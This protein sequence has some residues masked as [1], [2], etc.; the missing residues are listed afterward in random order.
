MAGNKGQK[1]SADKTKKRKREVND[2]DS[3]AKRHRK[4]VKANGAAASEEQEKA[5]NA[6]ENEASG[7]L[8]AANGD[9]M[10]SRPLG[11]L[12]NKTDSETGWRISKPMG[13]R[14]LDIDPILTDDEQ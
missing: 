5:S 4:E 12:A 6:P 13:G 1:S 2:A 3:K 9:G 8:V 14:M 10:A 7:T 11:D